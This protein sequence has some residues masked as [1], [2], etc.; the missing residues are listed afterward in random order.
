MYE[1]Y[2]WRS[3]SVLCKP[4]EAPV[5]TRI[6]FLENPEISWFVSCIVPLDKSLRKRLLNR[7]GLQTRKTYTCVSIGLF[8]YR[9]GIIVLTHRGIHFTNCMI[10]IVCTLKSV[11]WRKSYFFINSV[12]SQSN[13]FQKKIYVQE[14]RNFVISLL[15]ESMKESFVMMPPYWM[16][17]TFVTDSIN[18]F[19]TVK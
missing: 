5:S 2:L 17:K 7:W 19:L 3:W 9:G 13:V 11:W 14:T 6:W 8:S 4:G 15:L 16:T 1:G 10:V 18:A 12:T